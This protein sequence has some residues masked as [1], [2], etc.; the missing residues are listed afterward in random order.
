MYRGSFCKLET[1]RCR[2]GLPEIA[3]YDAERCG[4][5]MDDRYRSQSNGAAERIDAGA[6]SLGQISTGFQDVG[7]NREDERL[8]FEVF[9][10]AQRFIAQC[11]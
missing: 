4:D 6:P 3:V 5:V 2:V 10:Q 9:G 11:E 7:A 8:Q 1:G